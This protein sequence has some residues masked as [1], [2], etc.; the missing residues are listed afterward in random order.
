VISRPNMLIGAMLLASVPWIIGGCLSP[1]NT[2]VNLVNLADFPVDVT[3]FY[4]DNQNTPEAILVD[5][6]RERQFRVQP[7][8]TSSFFDN[9][10]SLQAIVIQKAELSIVGS[11]GPSTSSRVYRDGTDFGCGN[12]ITFTFTQSVL[13]TDLNIGFSQQP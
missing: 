2:T 6:G 3:L 4:D 10:N 1:N 5:V 8:A 9:C 13:A 11:I 7:G 12:T